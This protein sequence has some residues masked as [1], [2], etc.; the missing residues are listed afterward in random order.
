[1]LRAAC[2]VCALA[3]P[4]GACRIERNPEPTVQPQPLLRGL[5]SAILHVRDLNAA[6]AWYTEVLGRQPYFDEPFYVGFQV[7]GYELGLDPD[8]SVATASAGGAVPYWDVADADSALSVL[9]AHGAS[10]TSP[11][12]DVGGGVRSALV[13]DPFGNLIGIIEGAPVPT[14]R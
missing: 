5:R 2:I 14:G 3:I 6:K 9:I 11:V 4:A 1:M 8:T 10:V 12:Q 7:G 13:T